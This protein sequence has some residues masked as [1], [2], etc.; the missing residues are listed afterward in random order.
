MA[1]VP[2]TIDASSYTIPASFSAK[3]TFGKK[4][5]NQS[6]KPDQTSIILEIVSFGRTWNL[7][8]SWASSMGAACLIVISSILHHRLCHSRAYTTELS[9]LYGVILCH[10]VRK[11]LWSPITSHTII[12]I[13]MTRSKNNNNSYLLYLPIAKVPLILPPPRGKVH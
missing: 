4:P 10:F 7:L 9:R 6:N 3:E 8:T 11:M 13:F 12:Y 1:Y 5:L 2:L